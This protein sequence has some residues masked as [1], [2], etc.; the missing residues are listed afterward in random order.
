MLV[1]EARTGQGDGGEVLSVSWYRAPQ[2]TEHGYL[3]GATGIVGARPY[4]CLK[5]RS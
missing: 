3:P 2:G 1:A 4:L 5:Y